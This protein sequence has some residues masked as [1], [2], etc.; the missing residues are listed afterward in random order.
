MGVLWLGN[1]GVRVW[2][3]EELGG[4]GAMSVMGVG[5]LGSFGRVAWWAC[6]LVWIWIFYY[7]KQFGYFLVGIPL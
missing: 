3:I 2:G 4:V 6:G 1:C 5:K 7:A